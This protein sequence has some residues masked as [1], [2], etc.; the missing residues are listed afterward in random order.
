MIFLYAFLSHLSSLLNLPTRASRFK[1]GFHVVRSI[2]L[3]VVCFLLGA[4]LAAQT[5]KVPHPEPTPRPAE[6]AI[7]AA[8]DKYEVIAM[9]EAHDLKDID[10]FILGLVRNPAFP[11]KVDD[12]AVECG[13]SLYQP[14]LDAYIAGDAVALTEV[15][16]V[17]RN[18]TQVMC[19]HSAFFEQFFPLIRAINQKLAPDKRLRVLA[20]DSPVDWAQVKSFQDILKLPHRDANI[21]SVMEKEVLQQH[22]KALMLFGTLHL[23][24]GTDGSAVSIYEKKYPN[25]TFVISDLTFFNFHAAGRSDDLFASWP[26]PSLAEIRGTA[27]GLLDFSNLLPA[28]TMIDKNCNVHTTFPKE[29][30]RP[31]EDFVDAVLYLGSP[32]LALKE[33]M[34]A[35]IA[36]DVAYRNELHRRQGLPGI[37]AAPP[38]TIEQEDAEIMKEES[39]ILFL[40]SM[41]SPPDVNH[42]DPALKSA[43]QGCLDR[44]KQRNQPTK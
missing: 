8:F 43:I 30:Q 33:A 21:A 44:L 26:I 13:N 27:V 4:C 38:R 23:L 37:P 31:M 11:A 2:K 22:R 14:L 1:Y 34:P 6:Q 39:Q 36:L 42:P 12:I 15:R 3:I 17:W 19:G 25:V 24:H 28:G 18:T 5:V 20:G 40:S 32:D 35:D 10:D 9:P 16:K 41:P 29:L 7:L